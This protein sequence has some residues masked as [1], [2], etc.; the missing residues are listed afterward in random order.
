MGSKISLK[1][2]GTPAWE[3]DTFK[4]KNGPIGIEAEG[5][6]IDFKNVRIKVLKKD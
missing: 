2:N 3:I 1:V 5:H 4:A 6:A